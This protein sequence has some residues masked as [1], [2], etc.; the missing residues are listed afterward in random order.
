M[1]D[2]RFEKTQWGRMTVMFMKTAQHIV[3]NT[4][5]IVIY[6][7]D[8]KLMAYFDIYLIYETSL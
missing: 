5:T 6:F 4:D 3:T 1:I 2:H 8:L 7:C